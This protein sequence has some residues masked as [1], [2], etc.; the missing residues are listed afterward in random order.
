MFIVLSL[1]IVCLTLL[2]PSS[3]FTAIKIIIIIITKKSNW[4]FEQYL[5]KK[6][7]IENKSS[8]REENKGE[9]TVRW[10]NKRQFL[11]TC[12]NSEKLLVFFEILG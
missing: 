8:I 11:E 3:G 7:G 10:C 9:K 12:R 2:C 5:Y 1:C 6:T 4:S